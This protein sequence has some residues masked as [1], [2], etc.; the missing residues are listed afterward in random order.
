MT[1]TPT[2]HRQL[3]WGSTITRA[4]YTTLLLCFCTWQLT[5]PTGPSYFFWFI[6]CFPLLIFIP[7]IKNND[8]RALILLC[9]VVLMYFVK[10]VMGVVFPSRQWIDFA[11]LSIS[12]LLFIS[13]MLTSRWASM[14]QKQSHTEAE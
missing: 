3:K 13:A 5:R 7:G 10:G 9:F 6:Q 8:P 11:L 4:L 14:V 12:I 1:D 2:I